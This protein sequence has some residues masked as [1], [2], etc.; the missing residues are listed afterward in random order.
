MTSDGRWN[1]TWDAENRLLKAESRADTPDGSWRRVEW[2]YDGKGRRIGQKTLLWTNNTWQVAEDLKFLSDPMSVGR[3]IV[4]LNASNNA[5]VRSYVWG[6]DVSG[7]LDGAGGVGGLLWVTLNAG[8]ASGIHFCAYDGNGNVAAL[9]KARDG[10]ISASDEYSSCS[11]RL[12]Q[13]QLVYLA[14]RQ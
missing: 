4:E 6:L 10:T 2:T 14:E 3:H 8:T 7:S 1:Y 12:G 5:P 13:V 11:E 9:V